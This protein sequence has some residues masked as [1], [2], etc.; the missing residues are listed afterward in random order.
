[1]AESANATDIYLPFSDHVSELH[2]LHI[3]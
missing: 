1:M 3:I 2:I